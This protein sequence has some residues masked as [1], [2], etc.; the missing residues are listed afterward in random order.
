MWVLPYNL[1]YKSRQ[2]QLSGIICCRHRPSSGRREPS[3]VV[4]TP[5]GSRIHTAEVGG[6]SPLAPTK[7]A[8]RGPFLVLAD[9]RADRRAR[10]VLRALLHPGEH[11]APGAIEPVTPAPFLEPLRS[12]A[13]AQF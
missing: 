9:G 6:S 13:P 2:L 10:S 4:W 3:G 7:S 1:P 5:C 12:H 8:G 11:P